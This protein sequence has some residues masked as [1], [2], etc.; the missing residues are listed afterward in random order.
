MP[1]KRDL[2]QS[3][4][5]NLLKNKLFNEHL[6]EDIKKCEVFPAVRNNYIDFYYR[7]GRLFQFT[8]N[9]IFK[10]HYKF[11]SVIEKENRAYLSEN[12]LSSCRLIKNFGANYSR[13]KENC[14]NYS[15]IE[16]IGVANL[17]SK[18]SVFNASSK[19][20][21]LD[22]EISLSADVELENAERKRKLDRI[23]LLL[24]NIEEKYLRFYEA[25][26]FSNPELW[27][28]S[29]SEPRICGQLNRYRNQINSKSDEILECYKKYIESINTIF[30][31]YIDPLPVPMKIDPMVPLYI[32]G[33]DED[34]KK[35][36]LEF[37]R[38]NKFMEGHN[39]Y[40]KGNPRNVNIN[41]LWNGIKRI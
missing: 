36:G 14:S 3:L 7:G 17:Y 15:G 8:N 10:T 38:K 22:I 1:F 6:L 12:E 9:S 41:N 4:I 18:Y 23:D 30:Q 21:V 29:T 37:L 27:S 11:A 31:I 2:S 25:K 34:Q 5:N 33:F 24:Y 40:A 26:H 28:T 20:V 16:S 32:F 35:G 39:I 19:I 13:I